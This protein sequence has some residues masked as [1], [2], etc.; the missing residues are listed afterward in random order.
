MFNAH[1]SDDQVNRQRY[2]NSTLIKKK[3]L[4]RIGSDLTD[5]QNLL[6]RIGSEYGVVA[7]LLRYSIIDAAAE[8]N[9]RTGSVHICE[10]IIQTGFVIWIN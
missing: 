3:N 1:K 4:R 8:F 10:H 5:S 2:T 7:S 6:D 9:L